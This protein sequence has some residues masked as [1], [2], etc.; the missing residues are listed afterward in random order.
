MQVRPWKASAGRPGAAAG[1]RRRSPGRSELRLRRPGQRGRGARHGALADPQGRGGQGAGGSARRQ[2]QVA[3]RAWQGTGWRSGRPTPAARDALE[4][5]WGHGRLTGGRWRRQPDA[6]SRGRADHSASWRISR[7]RPMA[8]RSRSPPATA[9]CGWWTPGPVLSPSWPARTTAKITG[10][11][12][13]Q[14]SAWL[15]WSEPEQLTGDIDL[16]SQ[17]RIRIASMASGQ[18]SGNRRRPSPQ[19]RSSTPPTAGSPTPS[20]VF[21]GRRQVPGVPVAAQLRPGVRRARIR[22]VVPVRRPAVP[23]AA[24]GCNAVAV[25][26]RS[27]AAAGSAAT[28]T[29]RDSDGASSPVS[30]HDRSGW[31]GRAGG[32]R[33]RCLRPGTPVPARG[34]ERARLAAQP[35]SP[36]TSARVAPGSDRRRAAPGVERFDFGRQREVQVL[37]GS[38]S[39]GSR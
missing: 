3:A 16:S 11:C 13:S 31:A 33:C 38:G 10:L 35:C 32:G 22:P 2:G 24:G 34:G 30:R 26:V 19:G 37:A 1:H 6:G 21:C 28:R 12:W 23:A 7:R 4:I 39:T 18:P 9:T 29:N 25:R 17:R 15:A 20:P 14:D 5:G 27:P 36:A 8:A